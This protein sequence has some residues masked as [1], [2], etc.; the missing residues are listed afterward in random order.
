MPS[1][2]ADTSSIRR[3][4]LSGLLAQSTN[5]ATL[6]FRVPLGA[7]GW[8]NVRERP[9]HWGPLSSAST[10]PSHRLR[11]G[12]TS[13]SRHK[14]GT[15]LSSP[16]VARFGK[17]QHCAGRTRHRSWTRRQRLLAY[18]QK[19]RLQNCHR[20][21]CVFLPSGLPPASPKQTNCRPIGTSRATET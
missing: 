7:Q 18:Q 21:V 14:T 3:V 11:P 15:P 8:S 20:P 17:F 13:C 6:A 10:S 16:P 12:L 4:Y 5:R 19:S 9:L 2:K 1:L